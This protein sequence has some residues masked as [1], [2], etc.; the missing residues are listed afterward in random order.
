M[1]VAARKGFENPDALRRAQEMYVD[2]N[3]HD[4]RHRGQLENLRSLPDSCAASAKALAANR[5]AFEEKGVFSPR[6]IDGIISKLEGY[7]D[8]DL[9]QKTEGDHNAMMKLVHKYWHCG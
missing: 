5:E 9:R 6:M 7:H 2:F 8:E 4:S 1:V 3:I